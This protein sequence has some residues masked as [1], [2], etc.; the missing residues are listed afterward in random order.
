M[1]C[2]S[3]SVIGIDLGGSKVSG[4]VL[5]REGHMLARERRS[6]PVDT[7]APA[8]VRA[9]VAVA[10]CLSETGGAVTGVGIGIPGPPAQGGSV[11]P[12]VP[13]FPG[14]GE[15][16]LRGLLEEALGLGIVLENDANC[17]AL[18]E[19]LWGWG[20]G[21]RCVVG[22]TLGTGVG[23]GIV[24]DRRIHR[25]SHW[26]AGEIWDL[27]LDD[28]SILEDTLSGRFVATVAGAET[29]RE[30]AAW[31]R[32]GH[33]RAIAAWRTFG[34]K[35]A[36]LVGMI[37]RLLDPDVLVVGGSLSRAHDLY[38]EELGQVA[39][40]WIVRV[41]DDPEEMAMRGAAM[42]AAP[43]GPGALSDQSSGTEG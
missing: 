10:E 18:G 22:I 39:R 43:S 26:W 32:G 36:W 24:I 38:A 42:V 12:A 31:A 25:G 40:R 4:L 35:L 16:P 9:L 11:L 23:V 21:R 29:A 6:L 2:S 13:N 41:S 30:A 19:A 1:E 27:P 3:G 34:A 17:F 37:G 15:L 14:V 7:D 20:K 8:L 33:K 28:G 5:S